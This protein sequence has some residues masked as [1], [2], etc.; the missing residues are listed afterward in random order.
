MQYSE[1]V[2]IHSMTTDMIFSCKARHVMFGNCRAVEKYGGIAPAAYS[3]VSPLWHQ[4]LTPHIWTGT[5]LEAKHAAVS[6]ITIVTQ[7]PVTILE[8]HIPPIAIIISED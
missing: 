4:E 8:V 2:P 1:K 6:V 3:D 5:D 7:H